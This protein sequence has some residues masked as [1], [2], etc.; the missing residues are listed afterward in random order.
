MQSR[1]FTYL[2]YIQYLGLRYHGWQVQPS[3]RTVQGTLH[4]AIRY[5]LGHEDFNILGASRTDAGVSC[6]KGAFELFL[7]TELDVHSFLK[8]LNS[9]LPA[10]I[11]VFGGH[12][13]SLDFNII[14]DVSEKEYCYYFSFGLKFHPFLSA[15]MAY[16]DGKYDEG[17]MQLTADLFNGKHDFRNFCHR[18]KGEMDCVREIFSSYLELVGPLDM[19]KPNAQPVYRYR[20]SGKG[21]L[22]HQVRYM[23]GAMLMVGN[24][25]IPIDELHVALELKTYKR[26]W[27][28]APANGLVL[29]NIRF[30]GL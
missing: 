15:T 3:V 13:V 27:V 23:I 10:D 2:F 11:R 6:E 5:L 28:K 24:G 22:M 19:D 16:F 14:Q 17:Q 1:P 20:V 4:K 8:N 25:S 26:P 18:G 29:N 12:P 9:N 30:T 7:K 21:F